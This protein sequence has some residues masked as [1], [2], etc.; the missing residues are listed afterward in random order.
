[1]IPQPQPG[2]GGDASVGFHLTPLEGARRTTM[3][4]INTDILETLTLAKD[5]AK[6]GGSRDEIISTALTL[7]QTIKACEKA[8]DP[9]RDLLRDLARDEERNG[10]R[11][12][13]ATDEGSVS[14]TFVPSGWRLP[15]GTD[16]DA[17]RADLGDELFDRY[18][19]VVQ[20]LPKDLF[21]DLL[22][23]D[24]AKKVL[25]HLIRDEP[26]PRVGFKAL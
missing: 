17:V 14:V 4:T 12:N 24:D 25:K 22:R 5:L 20:A 11:V 10:D 16:I 6:R 15:K 3:N 26:K 19:T 18:F 7:S 21:E 1:M 13:W 23:A 8:I 2:W 9:L